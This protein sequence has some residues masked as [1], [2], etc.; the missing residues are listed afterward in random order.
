[1][2]FIASTVSTLF[3]TMLS[4]AMTTKIC[5]QSEGYRS[6]FNVNMQSKIVKLL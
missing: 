2:Y 4:Q 5:K 1:M 3:W 6:N